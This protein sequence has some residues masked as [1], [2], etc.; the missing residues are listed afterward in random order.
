MPRLIAT[1]LAVLGAVYRPSRIDLEV[2]GRVPE[3]KAAWG[4]IRGHPERKTY[5]GIM[6]VRLDAPLFWANAS[7]IESHILMAVDTDPEIK[8][9]L[10]DMEATSQLDTTSV[11]SLELLLTRLQE[12]HIDLYLV[13]VFY[14]ARIVLAKAGFIDKLG[15]DR[16]WHSISAGVRAARK[17]EKL[18]GKPHPQDID[19]DENHSSGDE[20]IAAERTDVEGNGERTNGGG[21]Q[22]PFSLDRESRWRPWNR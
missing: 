16:M 17:T 11:D 13:R 10:L 7:A 18:K 5:D 3:E 4:S 8:A 2:M 19:E 22:D 1:G 21:Y 6:V 15:P 14:Q 9:L 20:H 12:R